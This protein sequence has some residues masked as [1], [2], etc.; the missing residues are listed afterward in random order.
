MFSERDKIM[1]IIIIIS[2]NYHDQEY[3]VPGSR[4]DRGGG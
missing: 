1:A 4:E 3:Q 2:I